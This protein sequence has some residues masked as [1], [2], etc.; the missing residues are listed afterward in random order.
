MAGSPYISVLK[1][2]DKRSPF[3]PYFTVNRLITTVT[4]MVLNKINQQNNLI[5]LTLALTAL[6]ISSAVMSVIHGGVIETLFKVFVALTLGVCLFSLRFDKRWF[7]LLLILL[8]VWIALF[9]LGVFGISNH[10]E[11]IIL[12]LTFIFF[13]GTFRAIAR[14]VLF[15]SQVTANQIIGS[16]ALFLLLGLMWA[17]AYLFLLQFSPNALSGIPE[18]SWVA[19]F[20]ATAYFSF[21]TLTTLG[22]GDILPT[23]P[24]AQVIVYL[25]AITGLFYMAIVVSSLVSTHIEHQGKTHG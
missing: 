25:E 6:L 3:V 10:N 22:Y 7:R 12:P 1:R 5:Y 15:R 13:L 8:L 20:S 9:T 19:N 23:N 4:N 17:I 21:I 11:N 16:V 14:Q 24:I 18:Q 2:G